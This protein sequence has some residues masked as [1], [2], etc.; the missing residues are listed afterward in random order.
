[1][2]FVD[3][4]KGILY[5][6]RC[7]VCG[8]VVS[9]GNAVGATGGGTGDGGTGDGDAGDGCGPGAKAVRHMPG[10]T[11]RRPAGLTGKMWEM[12][13][14]GGEEAAKEAG[15]E[16]KTW[17]IWEMGAGTD[18]ADMPWPFEGLIC[19]GCFARIHFVGGPTCKM[20]GKEVAS[21]RAEYCYD[22]TMRRHAFDGGFSLCRYDDVTRESMVAVKY[23][24]KR[25]YLDFFIAAWCARFGETVAG[26]RP[27][28]LVPV[29]IHASRRRERGFN[30]AEVLAEGIAR[31][32]RIPMDKTS[33]RRV[34][35]TQAQKQLGSG[36]RFANLAG[37]FEV[38]GDGATRL[39]GVERRIAGM[40]ARK[41]ARGR[42]AAPEPMPAKAGVGLYPRAQTLSTSARSI[43]RH[44]ALSS[45]DAA[46][47]RLP[48]P[49]C[50]AASILARLLQMFPLSGITGLTEPDNMPSLPFLGKTVL[51][52]D[53]IYTT[54]ATADVCSLALK[55]AGARS[56]FVGTLCIGGE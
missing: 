4:A 40:W 9:R 3:K 15:Y 21:E 47:L 2:R 18:G 29:P 28:V 56:V 33:L 52:V 27:D 1:M 17:K 43:R 26:I 38:V 49:P 12:G 54:G 50:M 14:G 8:E 35:N 48:L 37:A 16:D 23:K 34:K 11:V 10:G 44:A 13:A 19:R 39:G 6:R 42:G 51:L 41:D 36:G 25:E 22:C 30:Q 5:P 7:P 45:V 55:K 20:C 53:D 32:F 31:R 24:N 46:P